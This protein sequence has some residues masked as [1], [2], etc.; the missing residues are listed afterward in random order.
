MS[1]ETNTPAQ[2]ARLAKVKQML[3]DG[4][5]PY[6]SDPNEKTNTKDQGGLDK[7]RADRRA[8]ALLVREERSD[9]R[10]KELERKWKGDSGRVKPSVCLPDLD[11]FQGEVRELHPDH[12]RC[13]FCQTIIHK[14]EATYGQGKPRKSR[15]T[16]ITK[17]I[18]GNIS[19]DEE[20]RHSV[21]KVVA[22]PGCVDLVPK[23]Q[24]PET[25]G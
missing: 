23:I 1:I 6:A 10:T 25:E 12:V 2:K 3:A 13:S 24:F 5:S 21:L 16:V 22:C 19:F 9:V 18:D 11:L 17:D 20:V 14:I 15:T 7:D 8:A 4:I